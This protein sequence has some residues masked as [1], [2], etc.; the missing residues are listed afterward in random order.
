MSTAI[1]HNTFKTTLFDTLL[2]VKHCDSVCHSVIIAV[3]S[4]STVLNFCPRQTTKSRDITGRTARCYCKFQ[5]MSNFYRGYAT[6]CRLSSVHPSVLCLSETFRY[7][8][9]IGWNTSKIIS[10][11]ISFRY[12]AR[13]DPNTGN[14][15]QR[16]H[17][18]N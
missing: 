16:E 8:D 9:H 10:R 5:C 1:L 15:V 14:L 18:Q 2:S 12:N 3:F 11:L 13:A 6:V 7:S 4:N 17:P